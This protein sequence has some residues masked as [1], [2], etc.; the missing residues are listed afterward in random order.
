MAVALL[1]RRRFKGRLVP[2]LGANM[3]EVL[4][5]C[6]GEECCGE[7]DGM[8][9]FG[10]MQESRTQTEISSTTPVWT[11]RQLAGTQA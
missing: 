5:R 3:A 4:G 9:E 10:R 6:C 7:E 11:K 8:Q 1:V 2:S